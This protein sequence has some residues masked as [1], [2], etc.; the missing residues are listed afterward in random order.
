[1]SAPAARQDILDLKSYRPGA[2]VTD[3]I[4]LNANESPWSRPGDTL[5]RYPEVRPRALR[6]RLAELFGV[7]AANLIVTRGSSEAID[8]LI[9]AWCRAYTDSLLTT[10]PTFEMYRVYANIQGVHLIDVPLDV[11]HNFALDAEAV[12]AKCTAATKLIFLCSP[13]NPTGTLI[14]EDDILEIVRRRSG[15]SVVVVDEAY[16]EFADRKS[17]ATRVLDFDNLVVL[18][19]LSKAHALAGARCGAAIACEPIIDVM[20][21][22]LAPYSFPTPVIDT[23]L[24]ALTPD[25]LQASQAAVAAVT[26]ER[27]RLSSS[28]SGIDCVTQVWPSQAN[29]LLARFTNL[30]AIREYL[31]NSGILIRDFGDT[32]GL[33]NCARIT[34]GARRENDALLAALQRY[35]SDA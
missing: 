25:R 2:Q 1:M 22:V 30:G 9:R 8:V 15:Q 18:R 33:D 31:L 28:L 23:V 17:L 13:N 26:A 14:P 16:V 29:F 35:G 19:T 34:I 24:D 12:I 21:K 6:N 32:H 20:S 10:P 7:P 4:R 11:Q 3:T 5:N 27:R